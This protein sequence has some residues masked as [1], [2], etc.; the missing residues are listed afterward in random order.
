M[1]F[2]AMKSWQKELCSSFISEQ[3]AKKYL[4]IS[5]APLMSSVLSF[6]MLVISVSLYPKQR[7]RHASAHLSWTSADVAL[8]GR[9]TQSN[10]VILL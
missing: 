2:S 1:T 10:A 4:Y 5:S 8:K 7:H 9:P 6:S 3:A